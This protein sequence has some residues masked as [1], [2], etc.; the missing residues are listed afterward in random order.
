MAA[1]SASYW[2]L[3]VSSH[4]F[5][6][7]DGRPAQTRLPVG[8]ADVIGG[9]VQPVHALV[10]LETV[11]DVPLQLVGDVADPRHQLVS[12]S[13]HDYPSLLTRRTVGVRR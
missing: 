5:C 8:L 6:H 11:L 2:P 12:D 10:G 4:A 1:T 9:V 3:S 7:H 13:R